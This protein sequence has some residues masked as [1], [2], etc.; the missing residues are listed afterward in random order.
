MRWRDMPGPSAK[1]HGFALY[2]V[3]IPVKS[4]LGAKSRL[5]GNPILRRALARAFALDTVA[6]AKRARMVG[7]IVIVTNGRAA[8]DFRHLGCHIVH[9]KTS[10]NDD[11]LN[12]AIAQGRDWAARRHPYE[13]VVVLP[14]DLPALTPEVFDDVLIV[15]QQHDL[16]FCADANTTGTTVLTAADP[17]A[18][19]TAYGDFSAEAHRA[20]GAVQLDRVDSRARQDIDTMADLGDAYRLGLGP[21]TSAVLRRFSLDP[22]AEALAAAD[23]SSSS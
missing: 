2:T 12:A 6:A 18:L 20:L 9:E 11:S 4:G 14:A 19:S 5:H 10:A 8:A 3:I 1:R 16:A 22:S 17:R 23:V 15:A 7:R 13:P 21:A